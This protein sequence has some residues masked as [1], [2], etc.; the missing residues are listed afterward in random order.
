MVYAKYEGRERGEGRRGKGERKEG[1]E[2]G[3]EERRE[4]EGEERRR[5]R[6]RFIYS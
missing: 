4:G 2:R 5:G 1:K 6:G 3:E